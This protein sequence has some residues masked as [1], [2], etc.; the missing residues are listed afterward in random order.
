MFRGAIL[1]A[2]LVNA[3]SVP[4][5]MDDFC[6]ENEIFELSRRAGR[7]LSSYAGELGIECVQEHF[8]A[9][10]GKAP[11]IPSPSRAL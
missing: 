5:R 11:G 4:E 7:I 10:S 8:A 3:Q 2:A 9:P 1:A 6:W